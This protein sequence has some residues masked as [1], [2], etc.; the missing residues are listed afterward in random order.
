MYCSEADASSFFLPPMPRVIAKPFTGPMASTHS[1][2][3]PVNVTASSPDANERLDVVQ[4]GADTRIRIGDPS[5]YIE[6]VHTYEISYTLD[7][8]LNAQEDWDELFW[9]VIGPGWDVP[10]ES[11]SIRVT[12]PADVL[13]V[14]CFAGPVRTSDECESAAIE[15]GEAVFTHGEIPTG[16]AFTVAV[17]LPL[18][19]VDVS[20]PILEEQWS[21]AAAFSV[22]PATITGT[23]SPI[24]GSS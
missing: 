6:G 4:I 2:T 24:P 19:A 1:R 23:S 15:G 14:I 22:T 17:Q 7:G 16:G 5:T 21:L 20:D 13:D 9:N 10:I 11:A 3:A 8:T 18:G 12:A